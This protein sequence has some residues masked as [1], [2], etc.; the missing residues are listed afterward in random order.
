[1]FGGLFKKKPARAPEQPP[2]STEPLTLASDNLVMMV[3]FTTRR[4]IERRLG[5]AVEYPAPGWKTWAAAGLRGEV[6]ILSA[7]Y[8]GQVLIGIGKPVTALGPRFVSAAGKEGGVR[9]IVFQH[10]YQARWPHGVGIISGNNGRVERIAL[11]A[12]NEMPTLPV[13]PATDQG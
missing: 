4:A 10:A 6:W 13:L 9:S 5:P 8:R 11:Y 3:G 7:I 2:V 1:M 12:N